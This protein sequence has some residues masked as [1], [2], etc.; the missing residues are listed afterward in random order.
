MEFNYSI[1][2]VNYLLLQLISVILL[3]ICT[4]FHLLFKKIMCKI[5]FECMQGK[6]V[7][8]SRVLKFE[9][10]NAHCAANSAKGLN[11]MISYELL[12][13]TEKKAFKPVNI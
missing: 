7:L 2:I 12:K 4:N 1:I 8:L 5:L 10:T 11:I 3:I 6:I 13:P 9:T